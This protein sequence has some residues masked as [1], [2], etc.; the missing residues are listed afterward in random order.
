MYQGRF[1][2]KKKT[3]QKFHLGSKLKSIENNKY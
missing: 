1:Y 2:M 3:E